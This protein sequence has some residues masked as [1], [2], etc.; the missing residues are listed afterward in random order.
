MSASSS[1]IVAAML[2]AMRETNSERRLIVTSRYRFRPSL[3]CSGQVILFGRE[4][5][6]AA[7]CSGAGKPEMT[8]RRRRQPVSTNAAPQ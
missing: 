6:I 7:G 5:G 3:E 1:E 8:P 4:E 2:S